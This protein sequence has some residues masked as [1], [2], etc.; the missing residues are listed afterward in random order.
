MLSSAV[1]APVN[2]LHAPSRIISDADRASGIKRSMRVSPIEC[3]QFVSRMIHQ[4][5]K[6]GKLPPTRN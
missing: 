2:E 3:G 1:K 6:K 5:Q 4:D